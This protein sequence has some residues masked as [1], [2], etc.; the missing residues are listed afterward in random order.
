MLQT[1]KTEITIE[2]PESHVIIEKAELDELYQRIE[3][4]WVTGLSWLSEQTG[5]KSPQ[6]LKEKLLYPYKD[7]LMDFVDYPKNQGEKWR[8][9]TFHMKHWLRKNFA[10][11]DK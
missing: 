6:Q 7:E 11:V 3:P 4:E 1:I 9:N 5:I 8:F 2:V 10:R